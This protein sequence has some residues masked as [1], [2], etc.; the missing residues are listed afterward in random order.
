M[1]MSNAI[2]NPEKNT[3]HFY[4]KCWLWGGDFG[5][6]LNILAVLSYIVG[7]IIQCRTSMQAVILTTHAMY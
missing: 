6:L 7:I 1:M 2:G 5:L 4:N 3:S